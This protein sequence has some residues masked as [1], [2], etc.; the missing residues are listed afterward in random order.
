M[1]LRRGVWGGGVRTAEAEDEVE[2]RLLL[3]V[4]V[5][6]FFFILVTSLGRSL[7]L[8]LSDTRVFEP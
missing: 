2:G 7:S 6:F 5:F 3:D 4:V 8:K 1:V